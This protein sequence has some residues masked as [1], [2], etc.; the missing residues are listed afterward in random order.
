MLAQH[1]KRRES[2]RAF[3]LVEL[4]VVVGIIGV[5]VGLLL[6]VLS[7]VRQQAAAT[8]CASNLRGMAQAWTAYVDSNQG[9]CPPGR[10]P[11]ISTVLGSGVFEVDDDAQFRPRW[12]ELI[13]TV[14]KKFACKNPGK[15][16]NDQWQ[17]DNEWF[18][19]PAVPEY[20]NNRNYIFGYNHQFL[21]NARPKPDRKS[22]IAYPVKAASLKAAQTIMIADSMGTAAG[23]ALIDR[24]PYLAD[25][26]K[27]LYAI[28]NKGVFIDPPRLV[29]SRSDFADHQNRQPLHRSAPD[30]R[31][32]GK[33][34]VVFCDGH[35]ASMTLQEMGYVVGPSGAVAAW[36]P[37]ATNRYFSGSGKDDDPPL[38]D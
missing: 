3:T 2:R 11:N 4:L 20:R 31:H 29:P 38:A 13:G 10:Q 12:Y 15:L 6:P 36:G 22:W 21:G 24:R 5:L 16:E 7:K 8:K 23:K 34:N 37:G 14:V 18:L 19:C 28:G 9:I 27:D 35:V 33:A 26:S 17:I 32:L 1:S 30:P 25:G